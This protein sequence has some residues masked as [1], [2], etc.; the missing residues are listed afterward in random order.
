MGWAAQCFGEGLL[1]R[2][3]CAATFLEVREDNTAAIRL[4]ESS[5]WVRIGRRNGYY[6]DGTAALTFRRTL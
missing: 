1:R 5:G 6:G 4:Y 2:R 3:G